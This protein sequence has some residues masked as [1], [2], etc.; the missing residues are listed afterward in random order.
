KSWKSQK[1]RE[2]WKLWRSWNCD[3]SH[4]NNE[5]TNSVQDDHA[6][7]FSEMILQGQC[8]KNVKNLS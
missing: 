7:F 6:L 1:L 2:S 5:D 3:K 4:E 8:E